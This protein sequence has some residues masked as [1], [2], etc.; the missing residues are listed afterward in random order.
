MIRKE[1]K[2]PFSTTTFPSEGEKGSMVGYRGQYMVG[3]ELIYKALLED[4]L[5]AIRITDP[6]AGRV[7]DFL[8][9]S[10]G[11]L[12]AYQV[13]W[14]ESVK[15]FSFNSLISVDKKAKTPSL[16]GQLADGWKKLTTKYPDRHVVVH[17]ISKSIPSPGAKIPIDTPPPLKPS[18]QTFLSNCWYDKEW[19]KK[20]IQVVPTGWEKAM[21][22][23][24]KA[25]DLGDREFLKFVKC[26]ELHFQYQLVKDRF[27]LGGTDKREINDIEEI[28]NKLFHLV[29]NEKRVIEIT[30]AELLEELGWQDRFQFR[31]LHEFPVDEKR[32]RPIQTTIN[33]LDT[34]LKRFNRGYLALTGTP[35][36][37]KSTTLEMRFRY[38]KEYRIVRYYAF[39]PDDIGSSRGEALNFLHDIVIQLHRQGVQGN[40][41][42][43]PDGRDE[44]KK[45][46][47]SQLAELGERWHKDKIKTLI[48]VDGL[49][50]IEREQTPKR[51]LLKDLPH[52]ES[53][54][55]GVLFILGSQKIDLLG[56]SAPIKVQL[57]Q[58]G[59]TIAM[60]PLDRR[61]VFAVINSSP[62]TIKITQSQKEKIL[63]LSEGHPLA[64]KYL[65]QK[66]Q[67]IPGIFS[68]TV[69]ANLYFSKPGEVVTQFRMKTHTGTTTEN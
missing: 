6:D 64:L 66:L 21:R 63:K 43:L 32:Y 46:L 24:Q 11:R 41:K 25:A 34:S 1:S 18:F 10:P 3:A 8:I 68:T 17:L 19:I 7:D 53:I 58:E 50:H 31:F 36:S 2:E 37:G 30:G 52:S 69:F 14:G 4:K 44:L 12:D 51:T 45:K 22:S 65:L 55:K 13:K 26:C 40:V 23:L 67:N 15:Y 56:L 49:D 61:A 27:P 28:S 62:L 33:Q 57:E 60:H 35:G 54:P 5:E 59:R 16:I 20:G 9:A 47:A 38:H 39:V 29:G 48:L 42:G